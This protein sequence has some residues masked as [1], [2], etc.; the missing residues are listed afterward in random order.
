M[1]YGGILTS[2]KSITGEPICMWLPEK[3][4]RAGTSEYVQGVE[5]DIEYDGKIPEG[6]EILELPQSKFLMFQGEPFEEEKY[7][8]AIDE[9]HQSMIKYNPENIGFKWKKNGIRVQLEP[10]GSRGY[11]GMKEIESF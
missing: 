5:V 10:I 6:F 1:R 9:V 8:Q 7:C 2:I 3:Y 4:R 11:I